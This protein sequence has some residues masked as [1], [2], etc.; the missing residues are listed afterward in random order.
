M[1][2]DSA[3]EDQEITEKPF[4]CPKCGYRDSV[5][6]PICPECGRPFMRDYLDTQV[7]PRDPDLTGVCTSKFWIWVFLL[8]TLGGIIISLLFSFGVLR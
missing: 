7:H 8:S 4:T 2:P 3:H 1:T 5:F 6:H